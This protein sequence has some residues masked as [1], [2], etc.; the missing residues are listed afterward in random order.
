MIFLDQVISALQKVAENHHPDDN[1][2]I[3]AK[4]FGA[5]LALKGIAPTFGVLSAVFLTISN[6]QL[7]E[8]MRTVYLGIAILFIAMSLLWAGWKNKQMTVEIIAH[9]K[10]VINGDKNIKPPSANGATDP[11]HEIINP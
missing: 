5:K 6:Q 2:F 8:L 4:A 11:G 10:K 7:N 1:V 3:A 9:F